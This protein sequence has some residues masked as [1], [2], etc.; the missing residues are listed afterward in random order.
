[1]HKVHPTV[2]KVSGETKD[3]A[4]KPVAFKGVL[5]MAIDNQQVIL[6]N[7]TLPGQRMERWKVLREALD[8]MKQRKTAKTKTTQQ[9]PGE[10]QPPTATDIT[11]YMQNFTHKV[12]TMKKPEEPLQLQTIA[13]HT[14]RRTGRCTGHHIVPKELKAMLIC[15]HCQCKGHYARNCH[16]RWKESKTT[17]STTICT[18]IVTNGNMLRS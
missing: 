7:V 16:T 11:K 5:T 1:V 10:H 17:S 12:L 6:T 2:Q 13:M 18:T 4:A 8:K 3:T 9:V 14:T 15:H